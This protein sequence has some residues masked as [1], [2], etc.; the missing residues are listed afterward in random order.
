MRRAFTLIELMVVCTVLVLITTLVIP[1]LGAMRA[2]REREEAYRTIL[3]LAQAGRE[4]AIQ[5]GHTYTLTL[6]NSGST[7]AL[8]R[9]EDAVV[10]RDGGTNSTP[11]ALNTTTTTDVRLP[12]SLSNGAASGSMGIGPGVSGNDSTT[13]AASANLPSGASMGN[14]VL[15]GKTASTSDFSLHFYPDGRSEGGGIEMSDNGAA[16]SLQID[17]Q[18]YATLT[19]GS[20]PAATE[21]SWEAGIYE[22][23]TSG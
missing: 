5:S 9:D 10:G 22:Q 2:S 18:G 17:R 12:R 7:L 1:N 20:L 6:T 19:D 4:T 14:V 16:R 13:D 11:P 15:G 21:S 3:R 8:N 23:R